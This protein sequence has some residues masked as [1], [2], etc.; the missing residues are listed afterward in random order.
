MTRLPWPTA[1]VAIVAILSILGTI[2]ALVAL[3]W[4]A[5]DLGTLVGTESVLAMLLL[6]AMRGRRPAPR[7][8]PRTLR[9]PTSGSGLGLALVIVAAAVGAAHASGC[10][11]SALEVHADTAALAGTVTAQADIALIRVRAAEL[12]Q[13]LVDARAECGEAG[14]ADERAEHYL[15]LLDAIAAS[16]RPVLACRGAVPEALR[17]W[18]DAI[19]LARLTSTAEIGLA[20]VVAAAARVV[21]LYDELRTCI[22]AARPGTDMP[23]LP[24]VVTAYATGAAQ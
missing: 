7:K 11:A 6:A 21:L 18:L 14:C 3:G 10:G 12:D 19:D 8:R 13:V 15:A 1:A 5:A 4:T 23:A 22:V 20:H 17:A 16:W 2:V 9:G 24:A